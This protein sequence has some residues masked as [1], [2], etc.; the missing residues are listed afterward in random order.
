MHENPGAFFSQALSEFF[1][2][3]RTSFRRPIAKFSSKGA[4]AQDAEAP[5]WGRSVCASWSFQPSSQPPPKP[6]PRNA[7]DHMP[8]KQHPYSNQSFLGGGLSGGKPLFLFLTQQCFLLTRQDPTTASHFARNKPGHT[9][10]FTGGGNIRPKVF[11]L[12]SRKH[13]KAVAGGMAKTKKA[14]Y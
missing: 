8:R 5:V 3:S 7:E 6:W 4:C 11:K 2:P 9:N 1:F 12:Y 14:K 10:I 13:K